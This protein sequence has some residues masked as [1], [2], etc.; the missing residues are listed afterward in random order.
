VNLLFP[1]LETNHNQQLDVGNTHHIY[2]EESG[3][4]HGIPVIFLHGGPGS[5]SNEN[6]RRYF[7]PEKYR[8]IIFDQRGCNRSTPQG[9]VLNNT[10]DDLIADIEQIRLHLDIDKW[11]LFGGSWGATLALLYAEGHP[12]HVAGMILRGTFLARQSDLDWFARTGANRIFPDYWKD[13]TDVIPID[14][15]NDLAI[16]FYRRVIEGDRATREKF[17]KAWSQWAGRVVTYNLQE[18][19]EEEEDISTIIH[20]VSIETHYAKNRYFIRENQILDNIA[21]IPD[22]PISIIH[23]RRDLTCTLESSWLLH[24]ALPKSEFIIVRD[25]GHLAGEPPMVDA[26]VSAT[27]K[28]ASLLA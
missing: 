18:P 4:T 25:G 6:H 16:A 21:S 11:L 26:L 8:I 12:E 3:N 27:N 19:K 1:E 5:G 15:H 14:E 9:A 28:M 2:V 22:A 10:T 17:A 23:G 13:F 7:D 20:R 24:Q